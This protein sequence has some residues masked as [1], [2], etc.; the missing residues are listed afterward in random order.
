MKTQRGF[1]LVELMVTVAIIGVLISITLPAY[2]NFLGRSQLTE[3][4]TLATS[5]KGPVTDTYS[6]TGNCPISGV[7]SGFP[8]ASLMSGSYTASVTTSAAGGKCTI[9]AQIKSSGVNADIAGTT[10]TL[11]VESVSSGGNSVWSCA[12]TAP[13]NLLPKVCQST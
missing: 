8:A 12:S 4:L 13:N 10:L 3:A 5:L 9:A 7:T 2:Q 11:T 1:T 6:Q